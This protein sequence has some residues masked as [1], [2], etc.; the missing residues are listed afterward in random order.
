MI[1]PCVTVPQLVGDFE[2]YRDKLCRK[3]TI[4]AR[5][6]GG[7]ISIPGT[8]SSRYFPDGQK[9]II[10]RIRQRLGRAWSCGG[11]LVTLT[12]DPKRISKV[13]AWRKVGEHRR[14]LVNKL[15]LYRR[16]HGLGRRPLGYLAVLEVQPGTGYPHVHL[17]FPNVR[18][19]VGAPILTWLWGHG[20]TDVRLRDA[21]SPTNYVCKYL[22]KMSGWSVESLAYLH[23][24][25]V[26]M[27]SIG[28]RYFL[29]KP[30]QYSPWFFVAQIV[31]P[32]QP[33][34]SGTCPDTT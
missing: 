28:R 23:N 22:S 4:L 27:Y 8:A 30:K 5:P 20:F 14:E 6:S 33:I 3:R 13:D 29:P 17:V 15:W 2:S 11:V 34:V 1:Y 21:V 18:W 32:P 19:L 24:F 31:G 10:R 9:Y 12:Y 7:Q 16:R 25:G 26:R